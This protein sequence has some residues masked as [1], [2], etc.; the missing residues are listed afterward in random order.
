[1]NELGSQII[2]G[3][4]KGA[5]ETLD[6]RLVT[7]EPLAIHGEIYPA[8][9]FALNPPFINPH[10]PKMYR[11]CRGFYPSLAPRDAERLLRVEVNEYSRRDKIGEARRFGGAPSHN[12]E[13]LVEAIRGGDRDQAANVMAT[14][15]HAR[16]KT[17]FSRM[18]LRLGSA[19]LDD[20]LGHSVSCTAFI[21]LELIERG[22]ADSWPSFSVLADYF[23]KGGYSEEPETG[24]LGDAARVV[25]GNI[26]RAVSGRGIRAL[27]D[28]ITIYAIEASRPHLEDADYGRLV[29]SWLS[30]IGDKP[31]EPFELGGAAADEGELSFDVFEELFRGREVDELVARA[32]RMLADPVGR[33]MLGD[34]LLRCSVGA[35]R[36]R[37]D[38]HVFTGLG[39]VLWVVDRFWATPSIPLTALYQYVDYASGAL[40]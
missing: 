38:P 2:G 12:F 14:I 30:Y 11:I 9:Q 3:D 35:Y 25:D 39:S 6:R 23:C 8:A 33:A 15:S 32:S 27:H 10:M 19:Y 36:G 18:L 7:E 13:D 22:E 20:S 24:S 40:L 21:L 16:G 31:A 28:T 26:L 4:V 17:E 29:A 34:Y 5:L 1:M 37:V